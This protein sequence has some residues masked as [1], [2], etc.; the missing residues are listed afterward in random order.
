MDDLLLVI[1][2]S[3]FCVYWCSHWPQISN[4][5]GIRIVQTELK[6]AVLLISVVFEHCV[7][8]GRS[9]KAVW[10]YHGFTQI[11]DAHSLS[12][13]EG[14]SSLC[15]SL[16]Y[17]RTTFCECPRNMQCSNAT[18]INSTVDFTSLW[19]ILF[20]WKY[21]VGVWY[22]NTIQSH[23]KQSSGDHEQL[24]FPWL[25]IAIKKLT[26]VPCSHARI[27]GIQSEAKSTVCMRAC[28]QKVSGSHLT[29]S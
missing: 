11:A 9:W 27:N 6:S 19:I 20:A 4:C 22:S 24:E 26:L 3:T 29:L 13:V 17:F 15:V 25:C 28:G 7:L 2:G 16:W 14:A 5:H 12:E 23:G 18:K 8:R 10:K 1:C 21:W